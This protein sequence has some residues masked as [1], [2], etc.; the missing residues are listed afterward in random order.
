V[1]RLWPDGT[2]M[3]IAWDLYESE[4]P[5]GPTTELIKEYWMNVGI[6]IQY[7]S[8]TRTLLTQRSRA[9]RSRC[10]LARRR[11]HG[12]PLLPAAEVLCA[13]QWRRVLLGQ[14]WAS[15]TS[16]WANGAWSRRR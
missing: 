5:K 15:G 7:K 6:E 1:H 3:I 12:R 2:P 11:D 8:I 4:T 16:A 10:P 9:T 13:D 14:L